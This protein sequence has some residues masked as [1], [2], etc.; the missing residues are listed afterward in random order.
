MWRDTGLLVGIALAG[1][2]V[3]VFVQPPLTRSLTLGIAAWL[4]VAATLVRHAAQR[5]KG[6][7]IMGTP[8]GN[9]EYHADPER[10]ALGVVHSV[11]LG[12]GLGIAAMLAS[13]V[14]KTL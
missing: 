6:R 5:A 4:V 11:G 7:G 12:A 1:A 9:A 2:A 10:F 3:A 8:E 13:L 14:A